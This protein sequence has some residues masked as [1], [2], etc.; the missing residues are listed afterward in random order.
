MQIGV[1]PT[2]FWLSDLAACRAAAIVF[3]E[4]GFDHFTLGGHVMT[5]EEGRYPQRPPITYAAPYRDPFVFFSSLAPVTSR[6]RFRTSVLI[7][8]MLA[9]VTVA[10]QAAD[11]ATLS[12]G[13]LDLGV[14]IS[15]NAQEYRALGQSF[16]GRARRLEEQIEVLRLLWTQPYVSFSG[17]FHEIDGLG[18][19]SLPPAI[20]I[21]FGSGPAEAPMRRVGR[22][23]DGW[24]PI[25]GAAQE[26]TTRLRAYAQQAGRSPEQ[27]EIAG[28]VTA[29]DDV[30]AQAEAQIAG[31]ATQLTVGAPAA[32]GQAE[33]IEA[34]LN[35]GQ[36]LRSAGL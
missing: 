7:L 9:T 18:L 21:W 11:L 14:G 23:G 1:S 33:G 24:L 31:G 36:A 29:G 2:V 30:I 35:A 5:A 27:I 32:L 15:W 3:D 19:G 22:L 6:I 13:R 4:A 34:I 12:D 28:S 10:K 26:T 8:P 17:E 25:L 20:P 16:N